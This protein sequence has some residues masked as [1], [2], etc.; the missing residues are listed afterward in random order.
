MGSFGS[1]HIPPRT[2]SVSIENIWV[3]YVHCHYQEQL[4]L[5][6]VLL[7][8]TVIEVFRQLPQSTASLTWP[9]LCR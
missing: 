8:Y 6:I 1:C 4:D 3:P 9:R 7:W 2:A 5:M